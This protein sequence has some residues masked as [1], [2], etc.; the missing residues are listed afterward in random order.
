MVVAMYS[1]YDSSIRR[2][3]SMGLNS[4]VFV[5]AATSKFVFD[6]IFPWVSEEVISGRISKAHLSFFLVDEP[7]KLRSVFLRNLIPGY[8]RF[9]PLGRFCPP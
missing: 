8:V 2:A 6:C 4:F 7:E 9:Q 5:I 1:R 3:A